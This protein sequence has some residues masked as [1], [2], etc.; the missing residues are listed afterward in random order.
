[1][2]DSFIRGIKTINEI[3]LYYSQVNQEEIRSKST[4]YRY[5]KELIKFELVI[6][7]GRRFYKNQVSSK[8][9]YDRGAHIFIPMRNGLNIWPSEQGMEVAQTLGFMVKR[10]FDSKIPD[11]EAIKGLFTRFETILQNNQINLMEE[12]VLKENVDEEARKTIKAIRSF[13]QC[14]EEL[15]NELA[16]VIW[17]VQNQGFESFLS[18]LKACFYE[19]EQNQGAGLRRITEE[20]KIQTE[21]NYQDMITYNPKFY[22]FISDDLWRKMGSTYDHR[23]IMRL[24]KVPMT[25]KEI[26][27]KHFETVLR[28][29]EEDKTSGKGNYSKN[30]EIEIPKKKKEN[31]VYGYLQDLKNWGLVVEAG[32]R[33][34]QGQSITQILYTRKAFYV[35]TPNTYFDSDDWKRVVN[36]IG[37][38][39]QYLLKKKSYNQEK[40]YSLLTEIRKTQSKILYE[41]YGEMTTESLPVDKIVSLGFFQNKVWLET[42][43]L[44]EWFFTLKNPKDLRNQFLDCF[45]P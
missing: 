21:S 39:V 38:A 6:E 41:T 27:E 35:A 29:I 40:F 15:F 33:I 12:L 42:L 14:S 22:Q 25:L 23:A 4:I 17:I 44:I 13:E 45:N 18:E 20:K 43:E 16:R 10:H 30:G 28:R 1:I 9:L 24:L 5:V 34:T 26:H 19:N 31:T 7:V 37:L 11:L 2:L 3:M 36:V 8:T 32:R